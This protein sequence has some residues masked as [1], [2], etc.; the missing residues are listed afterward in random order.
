MLILPYFSAIA[1]R[2]FA[3]LVRPNLAKPTRL[4][5][6]RCLQIP[7]NVVRNEMRRCKSREVLPRKKTLFLIAQNPSRGVVETLALNGCHFDG[8]SG[9]RFALGAAVVGP[10]LGGEGACPKFGGG[11]LFEHFA[12]RRRT[13]NTVFGLLFEAAEDDFI[14]FDRDVGIDFA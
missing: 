14:Q 6:V 5:I 3:K 7:I 10:P 8:R 13:L 11:D 4:C 2:G 9:E 12:K 1:R